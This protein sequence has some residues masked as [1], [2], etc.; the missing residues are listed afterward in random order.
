[1]LPGGLV[2]SDTT[3]LS[4]RY[5][6][7]GRASRRPWGY[8]FEAHDLRD[9]RPVCVHV[10]RPQ[11]VDA[12]AFAAA[13]RDQDEVTRRLTGDGTP[14]L[15]GCGPTVLGRVVVEEATAETDVIDLERAAGSGWTSD[16]EAGLPA[17]PAG[18]P[19]WALM[20]LAER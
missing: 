5:R 16:Q 15:V 11:V 7:S 18:L 17:R 13:L 2:L 8:V 14:P 12:V 6:L 1:M 10:A 3:V 9:G 19:C 4:G 20:A